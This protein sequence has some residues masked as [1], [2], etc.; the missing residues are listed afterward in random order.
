MLYLCCTN[1][2]VCLYPYLLMLLFFFL[3][4]Q[5]RQCVACVKIDLFFFCHRINDYFC[6][7]FLLF[8]NMSVHLS[9]FLIRC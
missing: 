1:V 2:Q 3:S 9:R 6:I 5:L 4:S 7:G 8:I